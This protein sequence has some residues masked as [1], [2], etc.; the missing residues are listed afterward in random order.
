MK[1][2]NEI[3]WKLRTG[4]AVTAGVQPV[5]FLKQLNAKRLSYGIVRCFVAKAHA[6]L[7]VACT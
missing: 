7:I 6:E 2:T 1:T 3:K 4:S 5:H